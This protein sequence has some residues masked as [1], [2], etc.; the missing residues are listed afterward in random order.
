MNSLTCTFWF[1]MG[2]AA[3]CVLALIAFQLATL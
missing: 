3:A 2:F 1:L